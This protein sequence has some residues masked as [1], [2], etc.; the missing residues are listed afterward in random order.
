MERPSRESGEGERKKSSGSIWQSIKSVL[1]YPF[2]TTSEL[3]ESILEM[4]REA[5]KRI[6]EQEDELARTMAQLL[7]NEVIA[8]LEREHEDE[9]RR[10]EHDESLALTREREEEARRKLRL[11]SQELEKSRDSSILLDQKDLLQREMH[12]ERRYKELE[13]QE[14]ILHERL[15]EIAESTRRHSSGASSEEEHSPPTNR[16]ILSRNVLALSATQMEAEKEHEAKTVENRRLLDLVALEQERIA[17][18]YGVLE[19]ERQKHEEYFRDQIEKHELEREHLEMEQKLLAKRRFEVVRVQAKTLAMIE[20]MTR[21]ESPLLASLHGSCDGDSLPDI[22]ACDGD[23]MWESDWT[24]QPTNGAQPSFS[25][26]V[27]EA[28]PDSIE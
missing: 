11:A 10:K 26:S 7:K 27:K 17:E 24:V 28:V 6:E 9:R 23:A 15:E 3:P 13:A 14:K 5:A 19:V 8:R 18:D 20:E 2:A 25:L 21:S 1:K 16:Q 4:H 22:E 12:I